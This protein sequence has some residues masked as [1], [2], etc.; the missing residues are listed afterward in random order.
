MLG[1]G[2]AGRSALVW[3]TA[4]GAVRRAGLVL[5]GDRGGSH[6]RGRGTGGRPILSCRCQVLP[7]VR[8]DAPSHLSVS[9]GPLSRRSLSFAER[10]EIVLLGAQGHGVRPIARHLGRAPSTISRQLR[11]NA[12]TRGGAL[13]CRATTA[14]WHA[15]RAARRPRPAKPARSAALRRH[16]EVQLAGRIARADGPEVPGP[17]VPWT[18]RRSV[19]RQPRRWGRAWSARSERGQIPARLRIDFPRDE[20]MRISP[21]A[22][23]LS[24]HIQGRGGPHRGL[25]ACLRSGQALRVPRAR[26]RS[27]GQSFAPPEIMISE[28]PAEAAGRAVPSRWKGDLILGVNASATGRAGGAHDPGLAMPRHLPPM[29]G[30]REGPHGPERTPLTRHGAVAVR[31]AVAHMIT[32]LPARLRRSLSWDQGAGMARHVDLRVE[33]DLPVYFC[34]PDSPRRRGTNEDDPRPAAAVLPRGRGPHPPRPRPARGPRR[35]PPRR[36]ECQRRDDP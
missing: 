6:E 29:P 1:L 5:G 7:E 27:R 33:H 30:H 31:D 8:R 19:R 10:E 22:I 14:Q 16:V 36:A 9:A 25:S 34:D 11:R 28:R 18:K 32:T 15:E 24:L 12:V 35:S 3:A 26:V 17:V 4:D 20:T 13:A 23:C 2:I 21:E